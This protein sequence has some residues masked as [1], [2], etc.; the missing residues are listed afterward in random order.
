[1]RRYTLSSVAAPQAQN[2][3]CGRRERDGEQRAC[4]YCGARGRGQ[5]KGRTH[6]H[7]AEVCAGYTGAHSG[8]FP[9]NAAGV[10]VGPCARPSERSKLT[11][12]GAHTPTQRSPV[13]GLPQKYGRDPRGVPDRAPSRLG[14]TPRPAHA[15]GSPTS[16]ICH[17]S[18][19]T[20]PGHL[21]LY[22]FRPVHQTCVRFIPQTL[23]KMPSH[24]AQNVPASDNLP[25]LLPPPRST[26]PVPVA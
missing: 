22:I 5:G 12:T 19:S 24:A 3:G 8:D 4:C 1:M 6:A 18:N 2:S 16:P 15:S 21:Y 25:C 11:H 13:H 23:R 10:V 17:A 9:P 7:A 14:D 20:P 26:H